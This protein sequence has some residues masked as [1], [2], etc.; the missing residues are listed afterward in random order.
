V[1]HNI[2]EAVVMAKRILVMGVNPGHVRDEI[3]NDLPYPRDEDSSAFSRM[4]SRIHTLITE[5][6]MPDVPKTGTLPRAPIKESALQILPN[7]QISEMIGLLESIHNEDGMADIFDLSQAIGKDFGQTL[8]MVKA[9]E[10]LDLVDTP[11][12][13]VVLTP[14]G[15]LFVEGDINVRKG[16]LHQLF[17]NLRIVQQITQLLKQSET[18][19]LHVEV[20]EQKVAEWLPNENP[21]DVL[22]VLI[23]WGRFSEVFGYNDEAKELYLDVGQET[24]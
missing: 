10:L 17:G 9:A 3:V 5:S 2:Q 15:K 14:S 12:Q 18:L 6:M 23:S 22:S 4:V 24:T 11:R 16:M 1:T 13:T 7:V 19:R 8:Y 20:I 21:N